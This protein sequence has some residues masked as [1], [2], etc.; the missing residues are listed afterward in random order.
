MTSPH[1]PLRVG[2]GGP[3]GAGKTTLTEMLCKAMRTVTRSRWSRTTSSQGGRADP[4]SPPG[5]SEG[6]D[7]GSRDRRLP[8]HR[9]PRGRFDQSG[10]IA[11][12]RRRFPDLDVIFI[13]SGGDNLAATFSPDLAD[14]TI[15]V[16]DVSAGEKSP[17]GRSG[18]HSIRPAGHQQD[19]P[20]ALRRRRPRSDARRCRKAARRRPFVFTDMRRRRGPCRDCLIHRDERRT[21]LWTTGTRHRR[22]WRP[23]FHVNCQA[24][25]AAHP[26][27]R[28][29]PPAN[30]DR[31]R[32]VEL[33]S[34]RRTTCL[35]APPRT[36]LGRQPNLGIGFSG[37]QAGAVCLFCRDSR[38]IPLCEFEPTPSVRWGRWL[39]R[40]IR[41]A[42]PSGYPRPRALR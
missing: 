2:I 10:A 19:G 13:E 35:P 41:R 30:Q 16:I 23:R 15:Y 8:A 25:G 28:P 33:V 32:S 17:Q 3:V 12:M 27:S 38:S 4:Q 24:A 14:L 37:D 31:G 40:S 42:A 21:V 6:A 1:G 9:H 20:C 39:G 7:P 26:R 34:W 29:E 36:R 22:T 18:D 11:E 5:A